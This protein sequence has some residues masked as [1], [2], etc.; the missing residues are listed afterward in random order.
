MSE[1]LT[2]F[3]RF[4][5]TRKMADALEEAPSTVQS[6]KSAGRIPAAHQP[7]VLAKAEHLALSI[8]AEDVIF[9]MGREN[10]DAVRSASA[11]NAADNI[12]GPAGV[13]QAPFSA[14][15][16][17]TEPFAPKRPPDPSLTA[18][19][20]TCSTTI[21]L[22]RLPLD[23]PGFSTSE[24]PPDARSQSSTGPEAKAA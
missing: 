8:T 9:P 21:A 4:G 13:G 10:N 19:S 22:P 16:A 15:E 3:D 7:K 18:S 12:G 23:S 20:P 5:G 14:T 1:K 17:A 11:T 6:W 24:R 2:L